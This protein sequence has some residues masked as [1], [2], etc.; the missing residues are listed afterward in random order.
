MTDTY[1]TYIGESYT[2]GADFYTEM[3]GIT[4]NVGHAINNMHRNIMDAF[5]KFFIVGGLIDICVF[6]SKLEIHSKEKGKEE[7]TQTGIETESK[8]EE[9]I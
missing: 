7:Q 8:G 9:K 2:F 5:G 4:K 6:G 3:Y 1:S